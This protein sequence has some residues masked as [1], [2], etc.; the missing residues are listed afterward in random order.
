MSIL[1]CGKRVWRIITN[2]WGVKGQTRCADDTNFFNINTSSTSC[3]P[4]KY[5]VFS[6]DAFHLLNI[7]ST[8]N[9]KHF[10]NENEIE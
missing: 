4:F 1:C 10:I 9:P 2:A 6:S 7:H 5:L 3:M 8:V